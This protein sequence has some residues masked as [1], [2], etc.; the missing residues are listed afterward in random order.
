MKEEN[1]DLTFDQNSNYDV[2]TKA[3]SYYAQ[4]AL[5]LGAGIQEAGPELTPET[6][7]TGLRK[8]RH[9]NQGV[10]TAPWWQPSVGFGTSDAT[11]N[12]DFALAWW[13][14]PQPGQ[15]VGSFCYV[16]DGAR[17]TAASMP[18]DADELFFDREAGCR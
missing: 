10:G 6:F 16:G 15:T 3:Y 14:A 9:P 7:A 11:L 18:A 2:A 12:D 8:A 17:F 1:P 4:M 13:S 5:V